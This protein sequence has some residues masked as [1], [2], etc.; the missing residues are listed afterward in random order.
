MDS[1]TV[2]I[3]KIFVGGIQSSGK[4]ILWRLLD[5]HSNIICNVGHNNLGHFLL[6]KRCKDYFLSNRRKAVGSRNQYL[7]TLKLKYSSGEVANIEIGR[8]FTA[9]HS[10][11]SYRSLY[12]WAKGKTG[13]IDGAR[14]DEKSFSFIFDVNRFE[15]RLESELFWGTDIFSEEEVIDVIYSSYVKSLANELFTK[16]LEEKKL[17][18]M[19]TLPNGIQSIRTVAEKV[20]DATILVMK[21]DLLSL[22]YTNAKG[23]SGYA[24]T[25]IGNVAFRQL[26]L[27]QN[28]L[29]EKVTKFYQDVA[30]IQSANQNI[31]FIDFRCLVLDTDKTMRQVAD[32]VEIEYEEIMTKPSIN[33]QVI[34]T[35]NYQ[36]IGKI[37]DDPYENLCQR[38]IALMENMVFGFDKRK[39]ASSN[40]WI[41]V[42][43]IKINTMYQVMR[44]IG[45]VL[46]KILPLELYLKL[47]RIYERAG[48]HS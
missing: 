44:W 25:P 18:F 21:R 27:G 20:P 37:N 28:K 11:S 43:R 12:S 29:K 4:N 47:K 39:S 13:F 2:G 24:K 22:L 3:K 40:M 17:C 16:K 19:D 8:F 41:F 7:P 30:D 32:F 14:D 31:Q 6:D 9:L 38:D 48:P 33:G 35:E 34:D 1:T 23:I 15:Q 46:S 42:D 45:V 10:F 36:I 26:L 5:G